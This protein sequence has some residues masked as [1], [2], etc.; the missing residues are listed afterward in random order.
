MENFAKTF[1]ESRDVQQLQNATARTFD[2]IRNNP[3]LRD[4]TVVLNQVF[5]STTDLQITHGLG[6]IPIGYI[7]IGQNANETVYT[8]ATVNPVPDAIVILKASGTVTASFL[9]F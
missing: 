1:P 6:R 2:S 4:P 5:T 8:S 7:I 9:F 3:L